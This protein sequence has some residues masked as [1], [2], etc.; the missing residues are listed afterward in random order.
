LKKPTGLA[1]Q[2]T[3][4]FNNPSFTDLH[5]EQSCN[6]RKYMSRISSK[7][8][9]LKGGKAGTNQAV[10]EA[11]PGQQQ[12]KEYYQLKR[13]H[14]RIRKIIQQQS[15]MMNSSGKVSVGQYGVGRPS[16]YIIGNHPAFNK[17]QRVTLKRQ[18]D[19]DCYD[20]RETA[21]FDH[22]NIS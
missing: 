2:V 12:I 22:G 6:E 1:N 13:E 10:A 5:T 15:E 16:N 8:I 7:N 3:S 21:T 19:I 4:F 18:G 14:E 20:V 11:R 9:Q 17:K